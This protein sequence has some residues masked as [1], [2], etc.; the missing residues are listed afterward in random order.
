M[1]HLP[2]CTIIPV[3]EDTFLTKTLMEFDGDHQRYF[4]RIVHEFWYQ[5]RVLRRVRLKQPGQKSPVLNGPGQRGRNQNGSGKKNMTSKWLRSK[6]LSSKLPRSKVLKDKTA[7]DTYIIV[8]FITIL[9]W[10][11]SRPYK[12]FSRKYE[13]CPQYSSLQAKSFFFLFQ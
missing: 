4:P 10:T 2:T 6:D 5:L 13:D 11:L 3:P 12:I 1:L 9:V 7:K 8:H